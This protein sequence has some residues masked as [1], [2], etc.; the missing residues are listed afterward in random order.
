[1]TPPV[2][3]LAQLAEGARFHRGGA[4]LPASMASTLA[5]IWTEQGVAAHTAAAAQAE[6]A[7]CLLRLGAPAA[8]L[9]GAGRALL[10]ETAISAACLELARRYGG[11]EVTL[12]P[13]PRRDSPLD[14]DRRELVLGT[15]R[16][17]CIAATIE[18]S[19]ARE[20]QEHCQEPAAREVLR[21]LE[22][23]RARTAQLS[24]R[25]LG[26][27]LR[28]TGLE[29]ADQVRVSVLTALGSQS[30]TA[31]LTPGERQ[32]LRHGVLGAQQRLSIEQRVLRDVVLPCMESALA[33]ARNPRD[34][35]A[36]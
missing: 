12:T 24:W 26:W 31:A 14:A 9:H 20:A 2:V 19:C 18:S 27:A 36:A 34:G 5:G 30:K 6:F 29:L 33:R 4:G 16:R 22:H 28:G 1:M 10:E 21:L 32:L 17:G 23:G 15:L 3:P 11:P 35:N 7:A 25:F 13:V 8:L